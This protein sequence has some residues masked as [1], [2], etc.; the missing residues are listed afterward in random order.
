MRRIVWFPLLPARIG[1]GLIGL[2]DAIFLDLGLEKTQTR[3]SDVVDDPLPESR[4]LIRSLRDYGLRACY[5]P[6]IRGMCM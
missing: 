5:Y 3:R 4:P 2:V 1:R 6:V